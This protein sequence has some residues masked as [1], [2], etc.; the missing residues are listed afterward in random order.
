[1][2]FYLYEIKNLVIEYFEKRSTNILL[3]VSDAAFADD[4]VSRKT[5][6]EYLFK[7]YDDLIDWQIVKQVI[8]I[9]S[10]IETELFVLTRIAKKIMW[11]KR[12]FEIVRL[13]SM[14]TFHIRCDN[15]QTFRILKKKCF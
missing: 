2:I 1:M 13:N 15:H 4:E 14:K 7:L 11:W 3:C 8:V 9:I 5:F 10:S 12:F 6:D